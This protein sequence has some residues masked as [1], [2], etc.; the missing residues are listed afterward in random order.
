MDSSD[1]QSAIPGV[2]AVQEVAFGPQMVITI[3]KQDGTHD[4]IFLQSNPSSPVPE[5]ASLTL[6][7]LGVASLGAC[8]LRRRKGA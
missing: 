2:P 5:P 7:G 1:G 3:P 4:T 8:A 6:L